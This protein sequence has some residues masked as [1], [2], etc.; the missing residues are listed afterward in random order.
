MDGD[1][2]VQGFDGRRQV[3]CDVIPCTTRPYPFTLR[4]NFYTI[5]SIFDLFCRR[6]KTVKRKSQMMKM[7][8]HMEMKEAKN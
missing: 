5:R 7:V 4:H 8:D 2:G 3:R 6:M 1:F